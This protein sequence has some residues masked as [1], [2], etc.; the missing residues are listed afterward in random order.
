MGS[1]R[2]VIRGGVEG[3]E[4]L[5]LLSQVN[6]SSTRA[7][8]DRVGVPTGAVCLDVG[9][10]GGDVTVELARAVGATGR[11]VGV[12]FDAAQIEIAR[13]EAAQHGWSN[14]TFEVL[15][16]VAWE[17]DAPFDLVYARFLLTHLPDPATLL[18]ALYR[19]V[20]PHGVVVVED[21]DFRGHFSEPDCPAVGR[22][23]ELYTKAVERR[24]AD[25]NIGPKL[26]RL[27]RNAGLQDVQLNLVQHTALEGGSKLLTCLTMEYIAEAVVTDGL[28]SHEEVRKTIDDL[29]AFANDPHTVH[30]G[31]RVFQAW[32]RRGT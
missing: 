26:P 2:Y 22:Y 28:A 23:V 15:D 10:G 25:P 12:D 11:V 7:L 27:L 4:R 29:Y 1:D 8:I 32:G 24:G 17:P 19:H 30:G 31:P 21:I 3:R 9:C 16:V 6:G 14:V 18:S 5:R 13:H 20:R